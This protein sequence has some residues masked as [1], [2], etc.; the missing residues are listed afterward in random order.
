M[1]LTEI[2]DGFVQLHNANAVPASDGCGFFVTM[3][4]EYEMPSGETG[5]AFVGRYI[6]D[7]E[8][9]MGIITNGKVYVDA[10][11]IQIIEEG[12][13]KLL[14]YK[15]VGIKIVETDVEDEE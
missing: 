15:T 1:A 5:V 13:G 7:E 3:L 6:P 10:D 4:Y 2:P 12:L 8:L 11:R 9:C 14:D